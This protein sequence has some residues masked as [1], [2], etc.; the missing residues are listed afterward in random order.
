[1]ASLD[2]LTSELLAQRGGL[3]L[4]AQML[5]APMAT[6][7]QPAPAVLLG[8]APA[9][10]APSM[11]STPSS[12][13]TMV[14]PLPPYLAA[15]PLGAPPAPSAFPGLLGGTPFGGSLQPPPP[16]PRARVPG[17]GV[18]VESPPSDRS[19]A[20]MMPPGTGSV[21]DEAL[22]MLCY[23]S[24]QVGAAGTAGREVPLLQATSC[25]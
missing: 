17:A 19:T 12:S 20:T 5:G 21:L 14:P 18:R 13:D 3:P 6:W 22:N 11:N 23:D 15:P 10:F 1:M 8:G 7:P 2:Q 24:T 9:G 4:P 16:L 25:Y